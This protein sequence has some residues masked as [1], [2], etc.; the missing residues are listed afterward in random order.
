M[1]KSGGQLKFER[2]IARIVE[3]MRR[4]EYSNPQDYLREYTALRDECMPLM[5]ACEIETL[6]LGELNAHSIG[7]EILAEHGCPVPGNNPKKPN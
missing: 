2:G 4:G 1:Q 3:R 5:T 6:R 7:S